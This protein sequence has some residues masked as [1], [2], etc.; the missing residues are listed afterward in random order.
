M[1]LDTTYFAAPSRKN[2]ATVA[3][4]KCC[5][6][7]ANVEK[8]FLGANQELTCPTRGL[9]FIVAQILTIVYIV[10][11]TTIPFFKV[12]RFTTE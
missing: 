9:G 5:V 1:T 7:Y 6:Q 2:T 8:Y 10:S 3:L 11:G 12:E 4:C